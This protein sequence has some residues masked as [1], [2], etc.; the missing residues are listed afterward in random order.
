VELLLR[1][2]VAEVRRSPNYCVLHARGDFD[3]MY[4]RI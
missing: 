4:S 2:A 1:D 3:A